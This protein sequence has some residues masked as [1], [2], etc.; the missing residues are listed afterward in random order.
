MTSA[1]PKLSSLT[2][3]YDLAIVGGGVVGATLACALKD[4]G[5]SVVLIEA[6]ATHLRRA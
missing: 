4:S 3:D 2:Y 5:L 1:A 6:E